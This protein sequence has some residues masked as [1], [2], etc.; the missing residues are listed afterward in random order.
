MRTKEWLEKRLTKIWDKYFSDVP[1]KNPVFISFGRDAT[2]RFGS[3]RLN[4]ENNSTIIKINGNFR[5]KNISS[6]I[7]DH[8]IAHELVHYSQ[9]FS[10]PHLRLHRYPH[11]GGII[12]KELRER[13]LQK[14]VEF[15]HKWLNGYIK[16][17]S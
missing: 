6:R 10:S 5:R 15:Y 9:G 2:Y 7:I 16:N 17:L 8:T 13:G 3:I 12:D 1:A 14:L 11:R 4:L